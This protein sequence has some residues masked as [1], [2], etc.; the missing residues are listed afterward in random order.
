[1]LP[2]VVWG[3]RHFDDLVAAFAEQPVGF[4]DAIQ[5]ELVSFRNTRQG[6]KAFPLR[7]ERARRS[8][9]TDYSTMASTSPA[10]TAAPSRTRIF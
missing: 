9:K 6:W 3:N 5:R 1:M 2:F 7:A 8:P 10:F 4:G